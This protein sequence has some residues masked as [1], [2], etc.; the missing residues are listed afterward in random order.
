MKQTVK[1]ALDTPSYDA[2]IFR[3]EKDIFIKEV[4][5]LQAEQ[6][7]DGDIQRWIDYG[8]GMPVRNTGFGEVWY[9][10]VNRTL[11]ASKAHTLNETVGL[12]WRN[13]KTFIKSF[14]RV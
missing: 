1:I 7:T 13:T 12:W 6:V 10:M 9:E 14:M 8:L 2:A 11:T 5:M 3:I 4:Y